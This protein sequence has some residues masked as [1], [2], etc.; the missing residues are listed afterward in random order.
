MATFVSTASKDPMFQTG[1]GENCPRD[2]SVL[3]RLA[4]LELKITPQ[5]LEKIAQICS[6][7]NQVQSTCP[8]TPPYPAAKSPRP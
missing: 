7:I 8:D 1:S 5:G 6:A 3:D 2:G 4:N